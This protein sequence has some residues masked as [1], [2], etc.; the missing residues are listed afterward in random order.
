MGL[1]PV[2]SV[3]SGEM[4]WLKGMPVLRLPVMAVPAVFILAAAAG[5][6]AMVPA[7]MLITLLN[8]VLPVVLVTGA[9]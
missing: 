3:I 8:T 7:S 2:A 6:L 9:L 5:L 4:I 1:S